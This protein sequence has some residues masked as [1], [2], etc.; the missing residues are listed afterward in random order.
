MFDLEDYATRVETNLRR[1]N[2]AKDV[3][4]EVNKYL[5]DPM[6]PDD[7]ADLLI[8]AEELAQSSFYLMEEV[9]AIVW[10]TSPVKTN[11]ET[12]ESEG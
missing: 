11:P 5:L 9:Q 4:D 1:I 12:M 7:K 3:I 10:G 2:L 8:A 6:Y